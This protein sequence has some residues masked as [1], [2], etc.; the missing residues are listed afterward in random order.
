MIGGILALALSVAF[1]VGFY[2]FVSYSL[3]RIGKKF[4]IGSFWQYCIPVYNMVLLCRCGGISGWNVVGLMVPI[5]NIYFMIHIWGSIAERLGKS[6]WLFGIV[7]TL[8][9]VT[10]FILAFDGSVPFGYIL[11]DQGDEKGEEEKTGVEE[12]QQSQPAPKKAGKPPK[13][14]AKGLDIL[15]MI[16]LK[17]VSQLV[18]VDI[19]TNSI[20]ICA[21]RNTKT[22]FALENIGMRAYEDELLSD[23]NIIDARFV[24]QELRSLVADSKIKTKDVACALSSYTVI[25]KRV[26]VP[27]LEEEE[28][29]TSINV[30][31]EN[32]I[33]FPLKDIYYSY[34]VMGVDEEKEEMMNIQIVA[35][36]KEIVDGCRKVF[37]MAGLNLQLLDVDIFCLTNLVEQVYDPADKSVIVIDIGAS[38]TNIAIIKG[39]NIEF[40]REILMGGKHLTGQVE[41]AMKLSHKEAEKRKVA[42]EG[43]LSYLFE[44]FVFNVASEITKTINFYAATKPKETVGCIYLT[45]GSSG[46]RGLRERIMEDTGIMVEFIDPFRL[47]IDDEAKLKAYEDY[48]Q[49]VAVAL[50]LSTRVVDLGS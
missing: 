43:E 27:F 2:I 20:K 48:R 22:G 25:T 19:G 15:S 16:G 36:K 50:S 26:S 17:S 46:V 6:Y 34:Y 45:G 13:E 12:G 42:D 4:G 33:P 38:V 9:F 41:K 7:T 24:S 18:G 39:P 30:E 10:V 35:A 44:D 28:L 8:A 14:G 5:V 21:L 37:S 29:E 49:F 47:L 32:V 40:T 31:V 23:G 3:Y 1:T 11:P